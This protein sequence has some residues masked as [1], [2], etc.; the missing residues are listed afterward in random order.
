VTARDRIVLLVVAIVAALA[1]A[2]MFVIQPRRSEAS[3]L[4][5][6][7]SAQQT[8]LDTARA[9]VAQGEQ[10]RSQFPANYA[11]LVRLGEAVPAD[12]DVP[13]LIYQIQGAANAA[14][15]DFRTLQVSSAG[16]S[17]ST[18]PPST[19]SGSSSGSQPSG[20]SSAAS[21]SSSSS[22]PPGVAV[23]PAGF[24]TEQFTFSL[25]GNFFNLSDFFNR[26]QK[27]VAAGKNQ[28]SISGR[29]MTVNGISFSAAPQ[30]F[31]QITASISATTYLVQ[32]GQGLTAGA[33]TA[34]P[35]ASTTTSGAHSTT[36]TPAAAAAVAPVIR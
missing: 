20:S 10:A 32:P 36:S 6:Q 19:S 27:F 9:Q 26:L 3:Q 4:S 34:G 14:H 13:S 2:W 24:P 17:S 15:V 7:V 22:L 35:A 23:G 31:P 33:T 28:L 11:K 30:G 29:L 1:A 18:P 25:Q 21:Q 8:Q 5:A 12:D 16:G